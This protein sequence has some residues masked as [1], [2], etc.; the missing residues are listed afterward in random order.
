MFAI[1]EGTRLVH[2]REV[3]TFTREIVNCNI[4]EVEA[5][6]NGYQ[7][8]DT[9]H[10][11]RTYFRIQDLGSTDIEVHALGRYGD[12]GLEVSLGGDCEL[13][14]IITALKFITQAL[15]AGAKEVQD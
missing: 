4:L 6:T 13:E 1:T 12:E 2:G 5:G 14:T 8:G 7:G 9:G 3:S 15:E 10:G 11:S